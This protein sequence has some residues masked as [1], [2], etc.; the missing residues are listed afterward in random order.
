VW[1]DLH[2]Y[3]LGPGEECYLEQDT[4]VSATQIVEDVICCDVH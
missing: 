2:P 4:S 1:V 3:A